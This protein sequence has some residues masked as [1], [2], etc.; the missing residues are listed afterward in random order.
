LDLYEFAWLT[1]YDITKLKP[2]KVQILLK[3]IVKFPYV[4]KE[5]DRFTI[6]L[7]KI[8]RKSGSIVTYQGMNFNL[9]RKEEV[10]ILWSLFKASIC[11]QSIFIISSDLNAYSRWIKGKNEETAL[12]T[13]S[14]VEDATVN[15]YAKVKAPSVFRNLKLADAFSY[16]L[17]KPIDPLL[18]RGVHVATAILSHYKTYKIKGELP[19]DVMGTVRHAA[20]TLKTLEGRLEAIYAKNQKDPDYLSIMEEKLRCATTLYSI[21]L[22]YSP[23]TEIPSFPY[24]NHFTECTIIGKELPGEKTVKEITEW[25]I[26]K[27]NIKIDLERIENE[28]SRSLWDW[29]RK[30]RLKEKILAKYRSLGENTRFKSFTFPEEDYASY[31]IRKEALS[32]GIRR[33]LNRLSVYYNVMGEDFRR[34]SGYL[35]LQEAVQVVASQSQRNDVFVEDELRYRKQ[36]WVIL[37]DVSTSLKAFSGEVKDVALSLAEVAKKLFLDKHSWCVLAFNDN[38]YIVKDFSENYSRTVCARIG[39]LEYSGVTYLPDAIKVAF[40]SLKSR[41][42]ELKMLLVVSDAFP[43]GYENISEEL[44]NQVKIAIKSGMHIIGIGIRS[45]AVKNYFPVYCIVRN[46]YELM[47]SFVNTFFLYTSML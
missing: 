33:I 11:Y 16:A 13:I 43:I 12:C 31:I 20:N 8:K 3:E 10:R 6:F 38:F 26:Q 30:N 27:F 47:K 46:P 19:K 40:N 4:T 18:L 15:A 17:M 23:L 21:L 2:G 35:D 34:E 39:G 1:S 7:P 14:L 45:R 28:A 36:A 25:L 32:R 44:K 9:S 5:E 37:V 29:E 42:E 22:K 41:Y 24:M